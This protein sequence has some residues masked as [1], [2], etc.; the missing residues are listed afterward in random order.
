MYV[1]SSTKHTSLKDIFTRADAIKKKEELAIKQVYVQF[2]IKWLGSMWSLLQNQQLLPYDSK[3]P[4][5]VM[6]NHVIKNITT[7]IIPR[8]L[9]VIKQIWT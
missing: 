6:C 7:I 9:W 8:W 5:F 1:M 2:V 3:L 4:P